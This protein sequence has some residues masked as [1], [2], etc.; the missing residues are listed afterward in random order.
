MRCRG[1][2]APME[3]QL[4]SPLYEP[5]NFGTVVETCCPKCKRIALGPLLNDKFH[6]S[7]EEDV[8]NDHDGEDF[9]D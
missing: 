1:C 2:N 8:D 6:Y 4:V 9:P 3:F 5:S 7:L